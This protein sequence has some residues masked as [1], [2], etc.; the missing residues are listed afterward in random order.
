MQTFWDDC[1]KELEK[2][3]DHH[4]FISYIAPTKM[5]DSKEGEISLLVPS[6]FFADW[7]EKH[8]LQSIREV[9]GTKTGSDPKIKFVVDAKKPEPA[10]N[11]PAPAKGKKRQVSNQFKPQYSFDTFVVGKSNEFAN[12]SALACAKNPGTKY[13]PLYLYGGVGLGKTH[14]VQS[15]GRM[16]LE[17][18]PDAKVLYISSDNWVNQMISKIKNNQ[19]EEFRATFRKVDVLLVDDVQFFGGKAATQE[20][21]FHTFNE[22]FHEGKQ[23]VITSDQFPKDI[24]GLEDRLKSR[25]ASGLIADIQPAD[26]E[27]KVAIINKKSSANGHVIPQEVA[28]FLAETI[29][30]NIRELEGSMARVIAVASITGRPIDL[31]LAKET[32]DGVYSEEKKHIGVTQIQKAVTEYYSLKP[33]DLKAKSRRRNLVI[34]RQL[35]MYI[36]RDV[37]EDSLPTIGKAFGGRDHSTVIHAFQKVKKDLETN[38]KL[39]KDLTAIKKILEI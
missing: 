10:A 33:N 7:I 34:P 19:M 6:T 24:K 16:I 4:N 23:I 36:C 37:T 12:A 29:R 17:N 26:V 8:Y 1:K 21:F 3:I 28:F 13:N 31:A 15:M 18:N 32:L 39:Y 27:T 35:A 38:T 9:I 5:T 25:F 20:E 2:R 11:N 30:S 14:L 22:L